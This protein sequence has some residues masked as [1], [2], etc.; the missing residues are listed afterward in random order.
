[1]K[2]EIGRRK[3]TPSRQKWLIKIYR[4]EFPGGL[5]VKDSTFSLLWRTFSAWP[6]NFHMP[7]VWQKKKKKA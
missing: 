3:K 1:M 6:R 7:Q 5:A 2:I 4:Q